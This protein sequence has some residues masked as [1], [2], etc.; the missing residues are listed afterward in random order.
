[1]KF[2]K[3]KTQ[4]LFILTL[5]ILFSI[6][7][8]LT[9]EQSLKIHIARTHTP[10]QFHGHQFSQLQEVFNNIEYVGYY[11]DKDLKDS[12]N[13]M[14]YSQAQF[15]LAPTILDI[16]NTKH[17]YILFDCTSDTV[18]LKKIIELKL[19]PLKRSKQGIILAGK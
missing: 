8:F 14:F 16:N 9:I 18:A 15:V 12:K 5:I 2:P 1:M 13:N 11:T 3:Q 7:G 10:F 19:K 17:K 6:C 4:R